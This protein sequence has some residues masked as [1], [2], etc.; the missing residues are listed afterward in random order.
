MKEQREEVEDANRTNQSSKW[1]HTRS[2]YKC[3]ADA[4]IIIPSKAFR[5]NE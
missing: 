5:R 2:S 1:D 4:T 3:V